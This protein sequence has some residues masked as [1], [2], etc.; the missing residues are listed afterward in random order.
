MKKILGF[1]ST[2]T[3]CSKKTGC[4]ANEN[5]TAKT[6]RK[7]EFKKSKTSS[8][9]LPKNAKKKKRKKRRN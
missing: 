7:G 3:S 9:L 1:I 4:P 2:T 5:L 8:G 6:N